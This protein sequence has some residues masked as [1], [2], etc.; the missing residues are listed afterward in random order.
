[1]HP[2]QKEFLGLLRLPAVLSREQV[3]WR[4]GLEPREID[5]L[6]SGNKLRPLPRPSRTSKKQFAAITVERLAAC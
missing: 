5:I 6:V 3:A 2:E 4:L 1:M